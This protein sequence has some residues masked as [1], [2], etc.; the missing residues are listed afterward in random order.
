MSSEPTSHAAPVMD[1]AAIAYALR[2]AGGLA[3]PF[4]VGET[5][6]RPLAFLASVLALQ[7]L[8]SR[9]PPFKLVAG[10]VAVAAMA[11]AF[12]AAISLTHAVLALPFLFI[13]AIGLTVFAALYAQTRSSSPFWFFLSVAVTVTPLMAA[14][15]PEL[16]AS[17][18][19]ALIAG[20][21]LAVLTTWLMHAL[22]PEPAQQT[23]DASAQPP[24]QTAMTPAERVRSALAGTLIVMVLVVLLLNH[25]SA[26]LVVLVTALSIVRAAGLAA[27]TQT[28]MGLLLGN[29]IGGGIAIVAYWVINH[30]P[31]LPVLVGVVIVMALFFGERIA[32]AG[33][34]APLLVVAASSAILLLGAGLNPFNDTSTVFAARVGHVLLTTVYT[35]G[36]IALFVAARTERKLETAAGKLR[37]HEET[38]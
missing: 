5:L 19:H 37:E 7:L 38:P 30:A 2:M 10:I 14:R 12:F 18:A 11:I 28:A 24:V 26:A 9:Q 4:I 35:V 1:K 33:P 3:V 36:M 27:G 22:F 21:A 20:M 34:K 15:S 25:A 29:L 17:L 32:T 16:A 13:L 31:S 6:D 8:A 23:S